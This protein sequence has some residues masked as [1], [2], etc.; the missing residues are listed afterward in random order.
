M[1]GPGLSHLKPELALGNPKDT[2]CS[3]GH[4]SIG[5][6]GGANE[7]QAQSC[8]KRSGR[9]GPVGSSYGKEQHICTQGQQLWMV[10]PLSLSIAFLPASWRGHRTVQGSHRAIS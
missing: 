1:L 4:F 2:T 7:K 8:A 10:I 9:Q 3:E 6:V 5:Q